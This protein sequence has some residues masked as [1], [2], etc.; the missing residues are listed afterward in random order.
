M[1][2]KAL[3]VVLDFY[4][5]RFVALLSSTREVLLV[6]ETQLTRKFS[7]TGIGRD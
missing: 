6:S 3:R 7:T 4:P 2:A 1:L 5:S